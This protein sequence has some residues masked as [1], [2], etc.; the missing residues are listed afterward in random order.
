MGGKSYPKIGHDVWIGQDVVLS[1]GIT[2]GHG[3]IVAANSLVTKDVPPFAIVGGNPSKIIRFRFPDE[4]IERLLASSW[5]DYDWRDF[6]DIQ[7]NNPEE[8]L[9]AFEERRLNI[10]P[11]RPSTLKL[12][13]ALK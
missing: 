8:F 2:I 6:A 4:V 5:W 3:A 13:E 10:M 11:Y 7:M 1:M 9:S 12:P